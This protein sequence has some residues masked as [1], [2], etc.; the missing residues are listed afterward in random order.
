ML[1]I[2]ASVVCYSASDTPVVSS[3][4]PEDSQCIWQSLRVVFSNVSV[5]DLVS[6]LCACVSEW[7]SN[8][9][10]A[11]TMGSQLLLKPE[12]PRSSLLPFS[13]VN[14]E[15]KWT[16]C[17]RGGILGRVAQRFWAQGVMQYLL[18]VCVGSSCGTDFTAWSWRLVDESAWGTSPLCL[19]GIQKW[20]E[21]S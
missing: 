19:L 9:N 7:V 2:W 16:Y 6:S 17:H 5:D 18:D 20:L 3:E 21:E 11:M 13:F 1:S 14:G 8:G 10:Q 4:L 15:E 12:S